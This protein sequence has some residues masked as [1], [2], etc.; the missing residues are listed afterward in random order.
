LPG[1]GDGPNAPFV[2]LTGWN[3]IPQ[4]YGATFEV[5]RAPAWLRMLYS[6]PFIDRFAHPLLVRR[7][8]G[9]LRPSPSWPPERLG[10]VEGGWRVEP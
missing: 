5:A 3:D 8:L 2:K 4:G 10:P 7:G 6:T 1:R 9:V